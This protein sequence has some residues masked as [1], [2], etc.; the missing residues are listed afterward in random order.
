MAG[1]VPAQTVMQGS[2]PG[3]T[4]NIFN[5]D[6]AILEAQEA[7]RDLGCTVTP[8]KPALGFDLKFHSGYDVTVPLKEL[9]G[10]GNLLTMI[11]RVSPAN[12][13]DEPVY[14]SQKVTVPPI[15]EE[16]KGDAYLQGGFDVGEGKYHV[17]WLMRDRT[18]R[19]CS[20]Y[21][22]VEATL[23]VRDRDMALEIAPGTV[24]ASDREAFKG[25][26][27][28][29]RVDREGPLNVKVMVNFAPQNAE[30]ATLQPLDTNALMSILRSISREPRIGK[31]SVVAFNMHEQRVIYRQDDTSQI[32]FPALGEAL[33]SLSLGTV[34]LKRLSQK[35][36]DTEFLGELIT[37]ELRGPERPD[38]VIFAGPKV[39]L[40]S[41]VPQDTLKTVGEPAFPVFYM[42]YNLNP[43]ANPWRDAIGNAVKY[44]KGFEYTITKPRD[45]FNAWSDIMSRIVKSKVGSQSANVSSQ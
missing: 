20:G 40:E 6:A 25:E 38:A 45:L 10:S 27:P 4:L 24:A 1:F 42:N 34:D 17:D 32:D 15:E 16:A 29:E 44:F 36:G 7:R 22:D 11:F 3:G 5:S 23:P 33:N 31:F 35:N 2:A 18:E 13:P 41:S 14:F 37:K 28:V 8:I 30:A 12:H 26:P 39:M 9:A 43:Q 19:V 21:W